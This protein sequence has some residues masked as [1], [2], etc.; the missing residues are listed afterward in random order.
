MTE[1]VKRVRESERTEEQRL[2][3]AFRQ[4]AQQKLVPHLPAAE[5]VETMQQL[6]REEAVRYFADKGMPEK[7]E[8]FFQTL[9]AQRQATQQ[10]LK[11]AALEKKMMFY[12]ATPLAKEE[13]E[14]GVLKGRIERPDLM[15]EKM[16]T[17]V[18]LFPNANG[19]YAV[20][21]ATDE[22]NFIGCGENLVILT[23]NRLESKS[24]DDV[25]GYIH[26]HRVNAQDGLMPTVSLD[27]DIPGEWTTLV[28]V[29]LEE[30]RPV[31]LKTLMQNN[32]HIFSM[33]KEDW[34]TIAVAMRGKKPEEQ[35]AFLTEVAS[36]NG[37]A[38]ESG[39]FKNVALY[40][41]YTRTQNEV[42]GDKPKSMKQFLMKAEAQ[43]DLPE[44]GP[45]LKVL[46]QK[47]KENQKR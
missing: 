41:F 31:T 10:T 26:G 37:F 33:D 45:V 47:L 36:N 14:D 5:R 39:D 35:I 8:V 40:D 1:F 16:F 27:G 30:S 19:A 46:Q 20:K 2:Y 32:V 13:L 17:G 24:S 22:K 11:T 9:E 18:C 6:I 29:S 4:A 15:W 21:K 25:L 34:Q 43:Q 7:T 28:P 44:K 42:K 12:H 38:D 23:D 3:C